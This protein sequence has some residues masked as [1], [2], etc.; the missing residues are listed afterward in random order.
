[1]PKPPVDRTLARPLDLGRFEE[2]VG[3]AMSMISRNPHTQAAYWRDVRGWLAF[4]E[5]HSVDPFTA[6]RQAVSQWLEAMLA[7][8]VAPKTRARRM[9]SL[10]SIYRELRRELVNRNGEPI[11]PVV[12]VPN[13]FSV[14]DGPRRE[15]SAAPN[16]PTPALI[17]ETLI[18]LIETC[19]P[20]PLGIRDRAMLR[21]LWATGI[22]RSSLVDM[23][24]E[25]LRWLPKREGGGCE[26]DVFGKGGKRVRIW[27]RGQAA[28]D[29]QA[30]VKILA[31]SGL[32]TGALWRSQRAPL[33][34]VSVWRII[35]DRAELAGVTE[36]CSPHMFRAAFLTFNK[37]G[38]EAKQ[39]AAGHSDPATT[40]GYDR[41][42]WRGREAFEGMPEIE[43]L[44]K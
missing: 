21:V 42:K 12:T 24:I 6:N 30:Y 3:M 17:P 15:G 36:R 33:G 11:D 34:P 37:A 18:K 8:E 19:G 25:K 35:R 14:E 22:R 41:A 44:V 43:D 27:V 16:T 5:A 20:D 38:L 32:R 23:Q 7:D 39:Q 2:F 31:D 1:M 29:L 10:C 28:T 9:S 4:C 26:T 40:A 13:P